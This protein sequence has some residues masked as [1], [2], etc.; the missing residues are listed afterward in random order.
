MILLR[1]L[2]LDAETLEYSA[3]TPKAAILLLTLLRT[4]W[5]SSHGPATCELHGLSRSA[6]KTIRLQFGEGWE[7]FSIKI[8]D[9]NLQAAGAM[10]N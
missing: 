10:V 6:Q 7:N 1:L 2:K 9:C 5:K 3:N 4:A 8:Q